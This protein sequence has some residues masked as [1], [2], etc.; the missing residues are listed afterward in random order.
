MTAAHVSSASKGHQAH[1][2]K[3]AGTVETLELRALWLGK[4]KH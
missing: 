2:E 4:V 1:A 3:R